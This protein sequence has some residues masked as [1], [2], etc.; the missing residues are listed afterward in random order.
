MSNLSFGDTKGNCY[1][2]YEGLE[3][4]SYKFSDG[5]I[6]RIVGSWASKVSG[7]KAILAQPP[8][9]Q[10]VL[11]FAGTDSLRDWIVDGQQATTIW[12]PEQYHQALSL[13]QHCNGIYGKTIHLAGHSLGGGLAAYCSLHTKLNASTIN[14]APLVGAAWHSK[15]QLLKGFFSGKGNSQ[16]T[17]Y[18]SSGGEFV[19][20]SHGLNPGSRVAVSA[21]GSGVKG[22]FTKHSLLNIGVSI[23]IPTKVQ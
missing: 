10:L 5:T 12:L 16:I 4:E 2:A 14:A 19:S 7:F 1:I 11:A 13:T 3:R 21:K 20:S 8:N 17:N 18:V 9:G 15:L 23:S 22:F 6:W